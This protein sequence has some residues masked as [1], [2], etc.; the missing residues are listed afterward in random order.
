MKA[1]KHNT[2][3]KSMKKVM[4]ASMKKF[5]IPKRGKARQNAKKKPASKEVPA[6]IPYVR[7]GQKTEKNVMHRSRWGTSTKKLQNASHKQLIDTLTKGGFLPKWEG[8]ACPH[9][10][11]GHLGP[12]KLVP[13]RGDRWVHR[14]RRDRCRKFVQPHDFHP[15]FCGG[16]GNSVTKLQDQAAILLCAA[17]GVSRVAAHLVL[18]CDHKPVDTIYARNEEARQMYVEMEQKNIKYGKVGFWNDVE[19]DEVDVGKALEDNPEDAGHPVKWEQWGGVVERG[20]PQTLL[21]TRLKPANSAVRAPSPGAMRTPDWKPT[22]MKF[23]K[24]TNVILHTDGARAYTMN[25]PGV[26]HDHVVHKKKRVK[27]KAGKYIWIRPWYTKVSR[28]DVPGGRQV[29]CRAGTQII[30]RFWKHLRKHL[31]DTTRK[32]GNKAMTR[33]I[34]SAQWTYWFKGQNLWTKTGEMLRHLHNNRR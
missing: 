20:A 29:T 5:F 30:D 27:T 23:L 10:A 11:I 2:I 31:M 18:D 34:R 33:K 28:H 24:D 32:P 4:K 13:G 19:A 14:C 12:L 3:M 6:K 16:A 17:A 7:M 25:I 9:C 1:M 21:L 22:A 26:K 8:Q 15:I